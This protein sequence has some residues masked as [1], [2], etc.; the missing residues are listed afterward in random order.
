MDERFCPLWADYLEGD[1]DPAGLEELQQLLAADGDL[2]QYAADLYEEHRLLG[3][4][5]QP[6]DREAFVRDA[7][8]RIG[9]EQQSFVDS[10]T[11]RLASGQPV[12]TS[13]P[14]HSRPDPP[15]LRS[16][17]LGYVA[18]AVCAF[19]VSWGWQHWLGRGRAGDLA[20]QSSV[21]QIRYQ[22][23][24][25]IATL[26]RCQ[27]CNWSRSPQQLFEGGRLIPGTVRLDQGV[28]VIQFDGGAVAVLS[29]PAA[30]ELESAGAASLVAGDITIRAPEEAAGFVLRTPASEIVDLGTEFSVSV[31]QAGATEV[32]VAEGAIEW[33]KPG[34]GD[35]G[36]Y[37]PEG[38]AIRFDS[39]ADPNATSIP[40]AARSFSEIV[41]H[42][43]RGSGHGQ[44]LA[45]EAFDYPFA[46]TATPEREA[47]GGIGW[48]SP[49]YSAYP[50]SDSKLHFRPGQSLQGTPRLAASRGGS[51][52][53]P[54]EDADRSY[55]QASKR[56]LARPIELARD[57]VYYVSFL[58]RR[59]AASSE[60]NNQG[61]RWILAE[62]GN[63]QARLGFGMLSDGRPII[64]GPAGNKPASERLHDDQ[65]YLFVGKLVCA[66]DRPDQMFLKVYR[67]D[68][69]VDQVEPLDWTVVGR[70]ADRDEVLSQLHIYNSPARSYLVDEV[71]IGTSWEAVT[72]LTSGPVSEETTAN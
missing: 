41:P 34:M 66:K 8:E 18:V 44:L 31:G 58:V 46:V 7:L 53:L 25:Y 19:L 15:L 69:E 51:L 35:G 1:L 30:L 67:S 64:L 24:E 22:P 42:Q 26:V 23:V 21:E 65:D 9:K 48:S 11:N 60:G 5:L 14:T 71:R 39:A 2:L 28:A 45:Y 32:H 29:G 56:Q 13:A 40:L 37:L 17:W 27:D 54:T 50:T 61:F 6:F 68:G 38:Q 57:G 52:A 55:R 16:R 12:V 59:E 36:Q 33:R 20:L 47:D 62:P 4:A 43:Q 10:V 3:L 63:L 49:W 70:G 72:P